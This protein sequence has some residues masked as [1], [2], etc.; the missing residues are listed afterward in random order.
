MAS[1]VGCNVERIESRGED[2]EGDVD[3]DDV[4]AFVELEE[5]RGFRVFPSTVLLIGN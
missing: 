2:E 5:D 4:V 1:S 3:D